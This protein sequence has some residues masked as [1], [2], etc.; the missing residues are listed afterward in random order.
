[1]NKGKEEWAWS[2]RRGPIGGASETKGCKRQDGWK[3]IV[4]E[5]RT[6]RGQGRT[7]PATGSLHGRVC[8]EVST[9]SQ[10]P[11]QNQPRYAAS[12]AWVS[13]V[14]KTPTSGPSSAYGGEGVS[15]QG[16]DFPTF[17]LE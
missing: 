12:P 7:H 8:D 11:G 4:T 17:I 16:P 9:S 1:M 6:E 13:G 15:Q 14:T 10:L 3:M 2:E 5:L